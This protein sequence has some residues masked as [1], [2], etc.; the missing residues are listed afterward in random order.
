MTRE[1]SPAKSIFFIC[2]TLRL[3]GSSKFTSA[4][5]RCGSPQ[6]KVEFWL[7][8][9]FSHLGNKF[10]ERSVTFLGGESLPLSVQPGRDILGNNPNSSFPTC[11]QGNELLPKQ[12]CLQQL[13]QIYL[14]T[15]I[16]SYSNFSH[17]AMLGSRDAISELLIA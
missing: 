6:E 1:L 10:E 2:L 12:V 3:P 8:A 11:H 15:I 17:P 14:D 5:L 9:E 13:Y 7:P 4:K 16:S